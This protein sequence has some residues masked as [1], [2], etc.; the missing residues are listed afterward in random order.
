MI[1]PD[2]QRDQLVRIAA[3]DEGPLAFRNML[4][5]LVSEAARR[6]GWLDISDRAMTNC[7]NPLYRELWRRWLDRSC[8]QLSHLNLGTVSLSGEE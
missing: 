4:V 3:W 1:V 5:V 2:L 6:R 7:S 8:K